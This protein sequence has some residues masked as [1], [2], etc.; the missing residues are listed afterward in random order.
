M[1]Q[2]I[3]LRSPAPRKK[4]KL[5]ASLC[6]PAHR[7]AIVLAMDDFPNP[8]GPLSQHIGRSSVPSTAQPII[9]LI[10][11][12]RVPGRQLETRRPPPLY[13]ASGTGRSVACRFTMPQYETF[14]MTLLIRMCG[15]RTT[16]RVR[17]IYSDV[18]ISIYVSDGNLRG[19]LV[20]WHC[21][22]ITQG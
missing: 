4:K 20:E 14:S 12:T 10:I 6:S 16:G 5:A 13:A 18:I 3:L 19:I 2:A 22:R 7:S 15:F 9:C 8:A 11:S 17:V 1:K 21:G